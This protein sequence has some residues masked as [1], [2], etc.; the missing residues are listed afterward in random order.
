MKSRCTGETGKKVSE[1][2]KNLEFIQV[3]I[4]KGS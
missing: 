2:S 4:R 3:M 1:G